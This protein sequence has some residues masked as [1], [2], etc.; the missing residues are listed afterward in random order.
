MVARRFIHLAAILF[1]ALFLPLACC[2]C[3]AGEEEEP[4]ATAATRG[5]T[6]R[7]HPLPDAR[8]FAVFD[9]GLSYR[10]NEGKGYFSTDNRFGLSLD[11]GYMRNLS[12]ENAVGV[13]VFGLTDERSERGGVRARYRRW[14]SPWLG[15]DATAG[16]TLAHG[17]G[18]SYYVEAPGFVG[19]VGVQAGGLL[20]ATLEAE[21][22]R[23]SGIGGSVWDWRIGGRLGSGAGVVGTV[24]L[25]G[26]LAVFAATYN[27][28]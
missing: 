16:I 3:L 9:L 7:P 4:K 23:F 17:G 2:V 8:S 10:L 15:A 5:F 27:F 14:L 21:Q 19:S 12:P 20:G 13:S 11:L 28:D 6:F 26:A 1:A 18:N 22:I 25:L 24:L